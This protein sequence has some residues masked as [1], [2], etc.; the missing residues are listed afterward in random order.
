[1]RSGSGAAVGSGCGAAVSAWNGAGSGAAVR[2]GWGAA[3]RSGSGAAVSARLVTSL[4][5]LAALALA[6]CGTDASGIGGDVDAGDAGDD[7]DATPSYG[8]G[9]PTHAVGWFALQE[10]PLGWTSMEEAVGRTMLPT[11]RGGSMAIPVFDPLKLGEAPK[12]AHA[13]KTKVDV[14]T[15]SFAAVGGGNDG[16][17]SAGSLDV[18]VALD[19][20][21]GDLPLV[22][23]LACEKLAI[24][25]PWAAPLPTGMTSFFRTPTCPS[26][27]VTVPDA[28]GR[29]IVGLPDKGEPS[30]V[31][32]GT[33]LDDQEKRGHTHAVTGSLVTSPNGVA[34]LSG[35]CADGFAKNG[36]YPFS[37]TT[38]PAPIALPFVQL[39]FCVKQ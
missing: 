10:C 24:A 1:M 7:A 32:G 23:L 15:Q 29:F 5:L 12:H 21:S 11:P 36:S 17:A 30:A 14:A 33:P 4:A 8:D 27:W 13:A 38:D 34:L 35:C 19:D 28:P 6:G 9:L 37:V 20:A 26:G 2:S 25:A 31:F 18:D 3:V 16:H 39:S 22:H